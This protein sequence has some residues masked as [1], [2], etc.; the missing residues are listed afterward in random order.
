MIRRPAALAALV[1][2]LAL[3]ACGPG[4]PSPSTTPGAGATPGETVTAAPIDTPDPTADHPT[5]RFGT[6]CADLVT[7]ALLSA[8]F[9]FETSATDPL[10]TEFSVGHGYI[11]RHSAVAQLGGMLC[12]WSNGEPYSS[13][14][15]ASEFRGVQL[16]ILPEA[17]EGWTQMV[18]YYGFDSAG[19]Q[20]YCS[21]DGF[22]NCSIDV[23]VDGYWISAELHVEVTAGTLAAVQA[24][25]MHLR[26]EA[27]A[28]GTPAPRWVGEGVVAVST[29][30]DVTLPAGLAG[31]IFGAAELT[32]P[33]GGGG[34]SLWAS[35]IQAAG[36]GWA[37]AWFGEAPR[38]ISVDWVSGGSW[39]ATHLGALD[40]APLTLTG[41]TAD[42]AATIECSGTRCIA[43]LIVGRSWI[44][45]T[46]DGSPNP[47]AGATRL[48]QHLVDQLR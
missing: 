48:A 14:T 24:L 41:M 8:I 19:G 2:L 10:A 31:E 11:P 39:I 30:C 40:G 13:M 18:E 17:S 33:E 21:D 25:A 45:A 44:I 46:V 28:F 23:F 15:G 9:P 3:T 27:A 34:W 7:P 22:D 32:L 16:A 42:D 4:S 5:P 12:E 37:C 47:T 29:D 35:A 36:D 1:A 26:G 6:G 20:V 43:Q 38:E